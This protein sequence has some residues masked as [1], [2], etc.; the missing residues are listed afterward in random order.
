MELLHFVL[1]CFLTSFP[2]KG[3]RK[4]LDYKHELQDGGTQGRNPAVPSEQGAWSPK[5]L[6]EEE[7]KRRLEAT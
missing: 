6:E 1:F 4:R 5:L 7:G 2:E 3:L